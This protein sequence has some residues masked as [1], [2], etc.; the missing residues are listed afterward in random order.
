MWGEPESEEGR[1]GDLPELWREFP[2]LGLCTMTGFY[3][4]LKAFFGGILVLIVIGTFITSVVSVGLAPQPGDP[5]YVAWAFVTEYGW[6][7][8]LLIG[9]GTVGAAYVVME[10]LDSGGF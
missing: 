5:F 7:A 2:S 1:L 10:M 3:E 4:Y 9:P 8:L 6:Q